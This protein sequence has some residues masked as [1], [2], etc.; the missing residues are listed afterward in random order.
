MGSQEMLMESAGLQQY[1][2]G[3]E[4]IHAASDCD[5]PVS[6]VFGMNLSSIIT[7]Q[8]LIWMAVTY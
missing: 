2:Q 3:L 8:S 4:M 7:C 6:Q 1:P 5:L